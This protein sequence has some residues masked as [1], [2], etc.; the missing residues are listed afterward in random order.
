VEHLTLL[1]FLFHH[2]SV[3]QRK[4][5]LIEICQ[6]I[7]RIHARIQ[8]KTTTY[9]PLLISRL[10]IILDY[11][12]YQFDEP[13]P[14]LLH[15][16]ENDLLNINA[17]SKSSN[18]QSLNIPS[19]VDLS[20]ENSNTTPQYPAIESIEK[21]YLKFK[22]FKTNSKN[23]TQISLIEPCF[24]S[25]KT[26]DLYLLIENSTRASKF[27]LEVFTGSIDYDL[28]YS[29]LF[30]LVKL[31]SEIL[32][33]N[34]KLFPSFKC[35]E[36]FTNKEYVSIIYNFVICWSLLNPLIESTKMDSPHYGTLPVSNQFLTKVLNDM[37]I[38]FSSDNEQELTSSIKKVD[39]EN[40]FEMMQIIRVAFCLN[41]EKINDFS[42][43]LSLNSIFGKI[44]FFLFFFKTKNLS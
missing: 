26:T 13:S 20:S 29:S 33:D 25:L 41:G 18:V 9:S 21:F 7:I 40:S 19:N 36:T 2:L 43:K 28:F 3:S 27:P 32:S 1:L 14:I 37:F 35:D 44:I 30:E 10:L 39:N 24:Y 38:V 42:P 17:K 16:I 22:S 23:N 12:L 31:S 6:C 15:I 5:L 11:I 34:T 4:T 8:D